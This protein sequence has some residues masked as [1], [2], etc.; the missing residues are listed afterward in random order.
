MQFPTFSLEYSLLQKN[1]HYVAG[2]D[3]VGRGCLAGPVVAAVAVVT[4]ESQ[5][6]PLVRDSK[7]TTRPQRLSL[8]RKLINVL[9]DYG[10][11]EASVEEIDELG[12]SQAAKL[13][14]QRAYSQLN[15]R[16]DVTLIDGRYIKSPS[17][18]GFKMNKGDMKHYVI[19][20]ASI[21]AKVYRDNLMINLA[22]KFPE[23][24]FDQHVGYGT[25][26]HLDMMCKHGVCE[27][28]RKSYLPVK[29]YLNG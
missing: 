17:L 22:K 26:L 16:P 3:E 15:Q 14:M 13:A 27:L 21:I 4:N 12:I 1:Y 19:S 2:I 7:L 20:A 18:T 25:K 28:H 9:A 6:L 24:G 29:K 8:N 10:I 11:G 23:Y 5:Y